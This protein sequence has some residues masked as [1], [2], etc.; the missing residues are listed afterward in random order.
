MLTA[1]IIRCTLQNVREKEAL[2]VYLEDP[3]QLDNKLL[4]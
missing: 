4:R 1:N 2:Q 3:H